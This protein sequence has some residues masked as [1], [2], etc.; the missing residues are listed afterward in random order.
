VIEVPDPVRN[1][2]TALGA[3]AW[4]TDLPR[5]VAALADEWSLAVGR[6][7]PDATEAFVAEA[8]RADGTPAVL[9]LQIPRAGGHAAREIAVLDRAAGEELLRRVRGLELDELL[10]L[11][12]RV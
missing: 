3:A 12:E 6:T 4:L 7:F 8:V 11:L 10:G 5:L 9:K 2:A 1:N